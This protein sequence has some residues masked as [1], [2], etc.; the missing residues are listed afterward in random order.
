MSDELQGMS[1]YQRKQLA[2]ARGQWVAPSDRIEVAVSVKVNPPP[3]EASS[4]D[5]FAD[6]SKM[7]EDGAVRRLRILLEHAAGTLRIAHRIAARLDRDAT[8]GPARSHANAIMG[9]TAALSQK[10][11]S[12][13][14]HAIKIAK[15]LG[16]NT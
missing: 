15:T 11:E 4:C 16:S 9:R 13:T 7:G 1:K 5:H 8:S 12:L 10:I 2:K 14:S 3:P 6:V